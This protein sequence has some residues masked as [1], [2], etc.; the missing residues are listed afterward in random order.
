MGTGPP[1]SISSSRLE[2]ELLD[3]LPESSESL[4]EEEEEELAG[5]PA[6]PT[7]PCKPLPGGRAK[8]E[9]AAGGILTTADFCRGG[10]EARMAAVEEEEPVARCTAFTGAVGG[11]VGG[12]LFRMP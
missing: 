2:L 11:A 3:S 1:V 9:L 8:A 6:P 10:M 5:L 7:L 12:C 4:E